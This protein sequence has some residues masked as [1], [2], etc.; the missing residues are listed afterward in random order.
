MHFITLLRT[1]LNC[2]LADFGR[3]FNVSKSRIFRAEKDIAQLPEGSNDILKLIRDRQIETDR[4]GGKRP[5]QMDELD[6]EMLRQIAIRNNEVA[7]TIIKLKNELDLTLKNY[8]VAKSAHLYLSAIAANPGK[9]KSSHKAWFHGHKETQELLMERN[10]A[11]VRH[12]LEVRIAQLEMELQ[13]NKAISW[14]G[15]S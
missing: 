9:M 14:K 1:S 10:N 15:G 5:L 2:S 3:L 8:V 13:M 11:L 6:L 4:A 12:Q 7:L